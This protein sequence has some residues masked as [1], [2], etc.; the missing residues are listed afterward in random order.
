M[1]SLLLLFIV[2]LFTSE[3]FSQNYI[4]LKYSNGNKRIKIFPG[5]PF[6]YYLKTDPANVYQDVLV[7][8]VGDSIVLQYVKISSN[9]IGAVDIRH[10]RNPVSNFG[11]YSYLLAV[12]GIAYFLIDQ[13]NNAI[14]YKRNPRLDEKVNL[15]SAYLLGA[16]TVG[17]VANTS[18]RKKVSLEGNNKLI[19][20]DL[21]HP[22]PDNV[23]PLVELH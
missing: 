20:L 18:R 5:D 23:R 7:D 8:V 19:L 22:K 16:G 17:M 13:F 2:L 21:I 1:K 3:T 6:N 11:S 15:T 10:L 14:V 4:V 9:E 12:G